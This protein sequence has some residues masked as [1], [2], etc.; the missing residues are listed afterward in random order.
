MVS[1]GCNFQQQ[2]SCNSWEK[3]K[4]Q[5]LLGPF[6]LA[7]KMQSSHSSSNLVQIYRAKGY[8]IVAKPGDKHLEKIQID[9]LL[10]CPM[11]LHCNRSKVITVHHQGMI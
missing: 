2:T 3:L 4:N 5:T 11:S 10:L 1:I 8:D 7:I 9:I 6:S